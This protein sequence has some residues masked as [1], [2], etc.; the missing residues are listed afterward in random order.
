MK[1]AEILS[2]LK[3]ASDPKCPSQRLNEIQVL[4][5]NATAAVKPGGTYALNDKST[6][7]MI[8]VE[9]LFVD[10]VEHRRDLLPS[11][12]P[13]FAMACGDRDRTVVAY[14]DWSLV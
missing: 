7:L 8:A 12:F 3:E 6:G 10:T 14:V 1:Q 5:A 13:L 2:L 9:T 11:L 4:L